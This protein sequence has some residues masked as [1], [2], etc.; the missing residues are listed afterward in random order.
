MVADMGYVLPHCNT[1][2]EIAEEVVEEGTVPCSL[3]MPL[4]QQKS[5]LYFCTVVCIV[6]D[7][8]SIRRNHVRPRGHELT[9]GQKTCFLCRGL[10]SAITGQ[11]D[12]VVR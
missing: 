12:Q 4:A 5:G 6:K 7:L 8:D 10:Y 3:D 1:S 11:P 9:R 2:E